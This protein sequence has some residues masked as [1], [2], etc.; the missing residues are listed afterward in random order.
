MKKLVILLLVIATTPIFGQSDSLFQAKIDSLYE[1]HGQEYFTYKIVEYFGL[2][3][4]EY[5]GNAYYG[6]R[7]ANGWRADT[8]NG[9]FNKEVYFNP[10]LSFD[11]DNL[12]KHDKVHPHKD[13]QFYRYKNG[14]KY[15][16]KIE[17]TL[18]SDNRE[19]LIFK[20]NI[21][22]GMAQ[23]K[24]TLTLLKTNQVMANFNFVDGE[25]VGE[26][27]FVDPKTQGEYRFTYVKGNDNWVKMIELDKDKKV[28]STREK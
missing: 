18:I 21:V 2:T 23:G 12:R 16:G 10:Y 27:V 7:L 13:F 17:D 6:Q 19:K 5:V 14:V 11:L 8:T 26:C 24:G 22:K 3:C 25:L 1:A 20:A 28:I 9:G 15:T 4:D